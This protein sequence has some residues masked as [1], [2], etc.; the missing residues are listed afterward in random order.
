MLLSEIRDFLKTRVDSPQW[1]LNKCGDKEQSITLYNTTGAAPNIALG[2]LANTSYSTKAIS[3]LIHW[4]KVSNVAEEKAQEVYNSLFGED[5]IIGNK[6][7]IQFKM[8]TSQ[9]IYVGTDD[10]G[11]LEYVIDLIIY[12][13]R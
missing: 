9:P 3:I 8:N 11:I 12:Y 2:G 10:I 6:R 13:E 7:V 4:G 1:Y 5:G